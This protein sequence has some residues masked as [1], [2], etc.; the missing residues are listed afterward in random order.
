MISE[1]E[2]DM[3]HVNDSLKNVIE[4]SYDKRL[5]QGEKE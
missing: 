3:K 5:T 1:L 4:Q 2:G